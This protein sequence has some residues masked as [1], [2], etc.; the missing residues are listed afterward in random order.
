MKQ[1]TLGSLFD[2]NRYKMLGNSL[3]IPCVFYILNNIAE[4]QER[5]NQNEIEI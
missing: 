5:K 1:L 2:G 3:A 4:L